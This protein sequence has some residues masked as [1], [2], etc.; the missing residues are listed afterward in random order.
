MLTPDRRKRVY[1]MNTAQSEP[2]SSHIPR[3][4]LRFGLATAIVL[5]AIY[6][7]LGRSAFEKIATALA[8]PCGLIWYL[9][10]F[11]VMFSIASRQRQLAALFSLICLMFMTFGSG[12]LASFLAATIEAPFAEIDPFEQRPYDY[13]IV[14]GGGATQGANERF[15]GNSSGDRLILAA[16]LYYEGVTSRL[17]CT[18]TKIPE[19]TKSDNDPGA[20]SLS[21]LEKLGVPPNAIERVDGRTTSEEMKSLGERFKDSKK[22]IGILTSA[23][24][25]RRA[26]RLAEKNGLAAEPL[27]ADF[28]SGPA[29]G[30]TPAEWLLSIIP[31]ADNFMTTTKISKEYLGAFIGR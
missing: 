16:Q 17:I 30:W 15:Q 21:I 20:L 4:L 26:T 25:L 29:N 3:T 19:L 12:L 5:L 11:S 14:L 10:L 31:Q 6:F 9:L 1:E 13:V 28:L 7:S 22:R 8:M 23:W 2:T 27:P 18:G 24:H